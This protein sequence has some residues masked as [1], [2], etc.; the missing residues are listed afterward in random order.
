M[1]Y[2]AI[3]IVEMYVAEESAWEPTVGAALTREVGRQYLLP[4]WRARNP[5]DRFRLRRYAKPITG[6][7]AGDE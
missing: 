3:W 7:G 1:A 6:E 2:K 5:T 4:K